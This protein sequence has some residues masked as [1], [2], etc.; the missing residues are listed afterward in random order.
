M[1]RKLGNG[2]ETRKTTTKKVGENRKPRIV[3]QPDNNR[4]ATYPA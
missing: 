3:G 2:K 4:S 1:L